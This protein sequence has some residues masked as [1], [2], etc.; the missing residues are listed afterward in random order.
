MYKIGDYVKYTH[1][2]HVCYGRIYG[3]RLNESRETFIYL[4]DDMNKRAVGSFRSE[5][6]LNRIKLMDIV[7]TENNE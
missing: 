3:I 4:I 1:N 5:A 6:I 2:N 7:E